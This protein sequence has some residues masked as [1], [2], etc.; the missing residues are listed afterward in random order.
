MSEELFKIERGEEGPVV[1]L[2]LDEVC[3]EPVFYLGVSWKTAETKC[4]I[5][6]T[7]PEL[8]ALHASL[9]EVLWDVS[10]GRLKVEGEP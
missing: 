10:A 2:A 7:L 4:V 5:P 1:L 6:L 3:D 9:G 8:K